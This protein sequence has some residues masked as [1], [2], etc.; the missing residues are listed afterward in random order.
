MPP[1][2]LGEHEDNDCPFYVGQRFDDE[3]SITNYVNEYAAPLHLVILK[4]KS[5][6]PRKNRNLDYTCLLF[7]CSR[8]FAPKKK[9]KTSTT[10]SR[11]S[12][13][14]LKTDCRMMIWSIHPMNAEKSARLDCYEIVSFQLEHTNG[15]NGYD[16]LMNESIKKRRGRKYNKISLDHLKIEVDADRYDTHDVKGWLIER[17]FTDATLEEATNLRYRLLKN[18]P[19]KD[20][21]ESAMS[22]EEMGNMQDYLFNKDLAKEIIAGDLDSVRKLQLVFRGLRGQEFGFDSRITTDSEKRYSGSAWQ[23][24]RMR[25]RLRRHGTLLFVDDSRSG[26]FTTGFCF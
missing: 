14:T 13:T 1:L 16:E 9:E 21:K 2:I 7:H 8:A 19:M 3:E 20:W 24:G 22:P 11:P 23:T 26:I 10:V 17:G 12:R 5:M 18:L 6:K 15:C 25:S 4:Q